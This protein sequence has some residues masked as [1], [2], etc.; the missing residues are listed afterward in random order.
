MH[1]LIADDEPHILNTLSQGLR[2]LTPWQI[3]TANDGQEALNL[4][5]EDHFDAML[6]DIRMPHLNG[7]DVLREIKNRHI[8]T[9][10]I[11]ITGY[12]DVDTAVQAMKLG[13]QRFSPKAP[14]PQRLRCRPQKCARSQH[15]KWSRQTH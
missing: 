6:L 10:V 13:C 14:Q 1:I 5:L 4:L 9:S 2:Q 12:A 7:I 8:Q 15:A 11:V 3:E